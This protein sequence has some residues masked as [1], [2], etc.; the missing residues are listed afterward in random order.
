MI[1][2]MPKEYLDDCPRLW[3]LEW[4]FSEKKKATQSQRLN[5]IKT[6][7]CYFVTTFIKTK[8]II[9]LLGLARRLVDME[10]FVIEYFCGFLFQASD[11][12]FNG[13][14]W[15][16]F[17]PYLLQAIWADVFSLSSLK[18]FQ[19]SVFYGVFHFPTAK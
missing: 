2:V 13:C 18:K 19:H 3:I 12:L 9:N 7:L 5:S 14:F 8:K 11:G 16:F 10:R 1:R 4:A 17:F 6:N 15:H